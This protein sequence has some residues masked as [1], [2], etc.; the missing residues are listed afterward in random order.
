MLQPGDSKVQAKWEHKDSCILRRPQGKATRREKA[1]SVL[2]TQPQQHE[3][4]GKPLELMRQR[5]ALEA[6]PRQ[7]RRST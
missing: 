6:A 2:F 3:R 5:Q 1:D 7:P 4:N